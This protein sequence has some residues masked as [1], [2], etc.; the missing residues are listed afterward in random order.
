[1]KTLAIAFGLIASVNSFAGIIYSNTADLSSSTIGHK[2]VDAEYKLIP[3]KTEIR[4]IPGCV[5][6]GDRHPVECQETIVLE[7]HPVVA[8]NISYVDHYNRQEG[9]QKEWLTLNFKLEDFA[10]EDVAALKAG[11][12]TWAH[13]FSSVGKAFAARNLDLQVVDAERT[14]QVVDVRNSKICMI[15]ENGETMPG[16]VEDIVYKPAQTTVKELTVLTK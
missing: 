13:P 3:T 15:M 12:P 5:A 4:Q 10:A 14:I 2:L 9:N 11:Y 8:V 7:S 1:M 6:T 16:C